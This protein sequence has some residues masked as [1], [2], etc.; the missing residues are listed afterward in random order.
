[1]VYNFLFLWIANNIIKTPKSS[2][3]VLRIPLYNKVITWVCVGM[4]HGVMFFTKLWCSDE[5]W[6]MKVSLSKFYM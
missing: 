1:M 5:S 2:N 6:G 4:M 3:V